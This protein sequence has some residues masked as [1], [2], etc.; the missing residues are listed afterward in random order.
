LGAAPMELVT[1][2]RAP[3]SG[4]SCRGEHAVCVHRSCK[5]PAAANPTGEE[6]AAD[7]RKSSERP[8]PC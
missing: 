6:A 2:S 4:Q 3:P 1:S 7:L 8:P 5:E